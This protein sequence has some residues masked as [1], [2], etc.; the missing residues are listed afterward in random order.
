MLRLNVDDDE[1]D[2]NDDDVE[3]D[4]DD[5]M[6]VEDEDGVAVVDEDDG[7]AVFLSINSLINS[8]P[9]C[10]LI[11]LTMCP[12]KYSYGY[13]QSTIVKDSIVSLKSPSISLTNV[14]A[15]ILLKRSC[16][17]LIVGKAYG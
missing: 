11:L 4:V 7:C 13:L 2:E 5:D 12:P 1:E 14:V 15:S 3:M 9:L 17:L 8:F 16:L 6:E 10:M